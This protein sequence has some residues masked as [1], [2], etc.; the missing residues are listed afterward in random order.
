MRVDN[1]SGNIKYISQLD[2]WYDESSDTYLNE[3]GDSVQSPSSKKV[4][5]KIVSLG[6]TKLSTSTTIQVIAFVVA[7]TTQYNVLSNDI[8]SLKASISSLTTQNSTLSDT[9]KQLT[10]EQIK[11]N[12][13]DSIH[14]DNIDDIQRKIANMTPEKK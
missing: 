9:I 3:A 12:A 8:T 11:L 2:L 10:K 4:E 14:S 1:L 6:N 5:S 13:Q 7:A